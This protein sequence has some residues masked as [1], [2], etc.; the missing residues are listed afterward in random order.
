MENRRRQIRRRERIA[1]RQPAMSI[2]CADDLTG[3]DATAGEEAR[4][5]VSP[6]MPAG[7]ENLT[8]GILPARRDW[9]DLGRAAHFTAHDNHRLVQEAP[10]LQVIEESAQTPIDRREQF[11]FEVA[12]RVL[13]SVPTA[14][15][16]L[17]HADAGFDESSSDEKTLTPFLA[18]VSI[19][20]GRGFLA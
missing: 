20:D 16:N 10:L 12:K 8:R 19:A 13:M 6:M 14:K 1:N 7:S 2:G 9:R 11:S 5:Y 15:I 17:N 4:K 3:P 18:T